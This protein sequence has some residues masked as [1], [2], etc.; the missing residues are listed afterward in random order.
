[1]SSS[2]SS[3]LL[4]TGRRAVLVLVLAGLIVGGSARSASAHALYE[5]SQPATGAQLE[6][7]GQLQVWFTE[8]VEPVPGGQLA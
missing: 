5:K 1:M 8:A 7:P 4:S 2:R 6:T 3:R